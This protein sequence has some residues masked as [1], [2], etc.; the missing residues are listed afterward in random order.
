MRG[1]EEVYLA[2]KKVLL[3][4]DIDLNRELVTDMLEAAGMIVTGVTNGAEAVEAVKASEPGD[5]D[6]ILMDIKMPEMDGYEATRQIRAL[7]DRKLSQ[8][9]IIAQTANVSDEDIREAYE[10]GMNKVL[11]KPIT[12]AKVI[13]GICEFL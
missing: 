12:I 11:A 3:A 2:D 13:E 1:S 7:S 10:S 9:P 5:F 4:E 6:I 8:I